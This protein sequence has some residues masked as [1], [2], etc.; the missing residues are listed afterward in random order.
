MSVVRY[1]NICLGSCQVTFYSS[2]TF[3]SYGRQVS[4]LTN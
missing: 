3:Q 2:L 1:T 4:M